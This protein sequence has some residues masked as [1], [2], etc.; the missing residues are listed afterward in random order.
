[1]PTVLITGATGFTGQ[2][3][4]P[5]LK[6][7][8][9]EILDGIDT[10]FDIT[11][12]ASCRAAIEKLRPD[13]V[14]HLAAI[15][16]VGHADVEAFYRVN[17]LGTMNL[18][19]ACADVA[20]TLKK[21][22]IASSANIY[23]NASEGALEETM[24]PMPVNHYATSK[25]AMEYMVRTWFDKLPIIV[26]RPFNY[27][28]VGQGEQFLVPKIVAHFRRREREIELGNL[29]VERDFSDVRTVVSAYR[30]LL[31]SSAAGEIVNLCS[32]QPHS[33]K[34]IIRSLEQYAGYEIN[35]RV[36]PQF[37]RVNDVKVLIGSVQKLQSLIP[38]YQPIAFDETLAW[39]YRA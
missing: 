14:V 32:G 35:V 7:H 37:L 21:I 15:S 12:P 6:L 31:V 20:H 24:C 28:G 25:V 30:E 38:T 29:E 26:V 3:L 2:Y 22:L 39:M 33:L 4:L 27:T 9:Y 34:S 11:D 17:V 23:G 5:E 8:G 18:L 16:F 1:M 36:N 10:E 13:Y 19:Q